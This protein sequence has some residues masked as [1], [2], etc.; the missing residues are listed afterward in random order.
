MPNFQL[1]L[2][3]SPVVQIH[4][5]GAILALFLGA[6]VLLLRKGTK[7]HRNTGKI[8][9]GLMVFVAVSSFWINGIRTFGPF[10]PIHLLSIFALWSV[11]L[12]VKSARVGRIK[13]HMKEMRSLYFFAVIGAGFFTFIP[14]RLMFEV[15]FG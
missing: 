8:W 9:V 2:Q 13:R 14:G 15:F 10:S 12:G 11:Y 4:T 7:I 1:L 6:L 3:A 5:Y